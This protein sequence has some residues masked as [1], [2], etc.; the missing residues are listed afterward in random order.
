MY[1]V[2]GSIPVI[3]SFGFETDLR[4]CTSGMAFCSLI[5]EGW[6]IVPG[7]PLDR[8]IELK[9]LEPNP[10]PVL[11][12]EFMVKTRRRKGLTDDISVV[13]FFENEELLDLARNDQD[14]KQYFS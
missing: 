9:I 6:S 12:R 11:A 14:L 7:D 1:I 3:D 2:K 8:S 10:V 5:F 13:K 4:V